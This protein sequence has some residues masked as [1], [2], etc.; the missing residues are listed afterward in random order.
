M[1]GR[2]FPMAL[3]PAPAGLSATKSQFAVDRDAIRS[4]RRLSR[5][6]MLEQLEQEIDILIVDVFA[7][8]L[9]KMRSL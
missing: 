7:S 8:Y 2:L 5:I 1:R 3:D 9:S 6:A 4:H